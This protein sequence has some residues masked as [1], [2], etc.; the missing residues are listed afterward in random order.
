MNTCTCVY[1]YGICY[2]TI[3][4]RISFW[5]HEKCTSSQIY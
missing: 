5:F 4:E 3:Y 2:E 1:I